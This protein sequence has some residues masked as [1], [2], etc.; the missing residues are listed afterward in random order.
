MN[1]FSYIRFL[2]KI[3]SNHVPSE[4]KIS[5][6]GILAVRIAQEYSRRV[7]ILDES[8]T[9]KLFNIHTTSLNAEPVHLLRLLPPSD[10]IFQ[11]LEYFDNEPAS[12]T[13]LHQLYRGCLK[14]GE[15]VAIKT[16]N[17]RAKA[18]LLKELARVRKGM[19]TCKIYFPKLYKKLMVEEIFDMVETNNLSR[20][21]FDAEIKNSILL[22]EIKIAN[23]EKYNL[24]RLHFPKIFKQYSTDKYL[25]REFLAG[26]SVYNLIDMKSMKYF[27]VLEIIRLQ[28][29]YMFIAGKY[30][31]DLHSQNILIAYDDLITFKDCYG[32]TELDDVTR[33]N[34][35]W[36]LYSLLKKDYETME[37]SLINLAKESDMIP[38]LDEKIQL[39]CHNYQ[40]KDIFLWQLILKIFK[41]AS[42]YGMNFEP[43]VFLFCKPITRIEEMVYKV[44]PHANFLVD[45]QKIL[46]TFKDDPLLDINLE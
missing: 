40:K 46:E 36:F 41:I 37:K 30:H 12:T 38:I 19:K 34:L 11:L 2:Q 3:K 44:I 26:Q 24:K 4:V 25:L 35:F 28:F 1:T 29:F 6:M 45:L 18:K 7:D 27:D 16:I 10:Q 9:S 39:V 42:G 43:E 5:K 17:A 15:E 20:L 23:E 31:A 8:A 33:K 13:Y 22:N 14:N 21:S 32:I